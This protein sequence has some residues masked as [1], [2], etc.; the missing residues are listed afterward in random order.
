MLYKPLISGL[1]VLVLGSV[2]LGEPVQLSE[3]DSE[4]LRSLDKRMAVLEARLTELKVSI[5]KKFEQTDQR[6]ELVDKR[7]E[8]VDKRMGS[9][10]TFIK[11]LLGIFTAMTIAT[12]GFAIWDRTSA[13]R[14]VEQRVTEP[15]RIAQDERKKKIE[16]LGKEVTRLSGAY[17]ELRTI[18]SKANL[19]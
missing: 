17:E 15:A 13:S 5:E 19:L 6:F 7:F 10:I 11:I 8:Q 4:M 3:Q 1:V 14:L 12:I 2:V 16:D 18:L 9:K